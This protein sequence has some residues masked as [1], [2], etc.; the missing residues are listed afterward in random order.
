MTLRNLTITGVDMGIAAP[1][2][3]TQALVYDNTLVGNNLWQLSPVNFLE[4]NLTWNDD[5]IR[6]PGQ[7]NAAFQNTIS[8]FGDSFAYASHNSGAETN[9][10][11]IHFYRNDI[12][13]SGD[14][15]IE[16]DHG[17]RNVSWYDNRSHNSMNCGSLDPL[18]GGPWLS[19]RNIC[20]NP[21]RSRIHKWNNDNT[22]QFLYNN[23]VINTKSRVDSLSRATD[24]AL[25]YQPNNGAQ[26]AYGYRNNVQVYLGD[27]QSLWLESSGHDPIDWTHNSWFPNRPIQW[28][29]VFSNLAAAQAGLG[30]TTPVFSGSNRRMQ[31]D[32]ITESNPWTTTITAGFGSDSLMPVSN[33]FT[34]ILR[35]GT[36]PK[37]SGVV[38]PNITDGF[39]GAAPDRGAI[40]EGRPIPQYGDCSRP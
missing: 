3:L 31:N 15:L 14:D 4:T 1:V 37:N 11:S 6:L 22:G 7:G 33:T 24:I 34:P 39:S 17:R 8:R 29:G 12:R 19:A 10:Y 23:T 13:N 25:W 9:N 16:V 35:P 28:G 18:Y 36:S 5:G 30:T 40:I 2:E 38:I 26:R 21:Y 20:I 32:N 27:G